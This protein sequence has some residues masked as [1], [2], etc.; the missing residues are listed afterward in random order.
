MTACRV[1]VSR[2]RTFF[3][4]DPSQLSLADGRA[5]VMSNLGTV[6]ALDPADG[7]VLWLS[8]Y[9]RD[10][11]VQPELM[12]QADASGPASTRPWGRNPVVVQGGRVFALPTDA[13]E[14]FV[15][16]AASG[17]QVQ[18]VE[19][20]DYENAD[21]L[22]GVRDGYAVLTS[23]RSIFGVDWQR[24]SHDHP[25]RSQWAEHVFGE[26]GNVGAPLNMAGRA[27]LTADGIYVVNGQNLAEID[28]RRHKIVAT[29]PARGTFQQNGGQEPGNLLVTSRNVVVAG[30]DRVDVYTDLGLVTARYT[31]EVAAS[32][33]DP[34]PRVRF[35]NALFAAGRTADAVA[36][37][38]EAIGLL[39][40]RGGMRPGAGRR[41]VFDTLLDFARRSAT[42]TGGVLPADAAA[43][44]DPLYDRAA[45][46]A[47]GPDQTV[48]YL[49]A[50]ARFDHDTNRGGPEVELCQRVL[51][52]PALRP[53]PVSDDQTAAAAATAAIAAAV[54]V[55]RA[56]YAPV[57]ARAAAAL[58]AA[59]QAGDTDAL[60]A[61]SDVYPNSGAASDARQAAV[62]RFEA[63]GQPMR[64]V[65]VLR[66]TY[67]LAASRPT[68]RPAVLERIATAFLA[69]GPGGA[70]PAADRMARAAVLAT[71]DPHLA[72]DFP[73]PDGTTLHG[74]TDTYV[75]AV[76][77]LR[78]ELARQSMAGL[79]DFRLP[80][81]QQAETQFEA[82]HGGA[83]R[84]PDSP[85]LNPFLPT[86][87][88]I[89]DVVAVVHPDRPF[90]RNDRVVTWS[91]AGLGVYAVGQ[92][93]PAFTVASVDEP[94]VGGA[95][96]GG[97]L[98]AWTGGRLTAVG[99]DDGRPAWAV[100]VAGLAPLPA[101]ANPVGTAVVDDVPAAV[102]DADNNNVPGQING[103]VINIRVNGLGQRVL[104]VR[105]GQ[106][107]IGP[108]GVQGGG[109][110][111]APPPAGLGGGE[112]I[113]AV[114]PAGDTLVVAT[115]RGRLVGVDA[116]TGSVRWQARPSDRAADAVLANGHYAVVRLDDGGGSQVVVYDVPTGRTIGRRRFGSAGQPNQL[117]NV[118]LG[119]EATLV[120][121]RANS[122]E[123]KDLYDPWRDPMTPLVARSMPDTTDY[124]GLTQPDQLLVQAGRVV[125]L[126]ASGGNWRAW[127]L[128]QTTQEASPPMVASTAAVATGTPNV[129]LRLDGPRLLVVQP[130]TGVSQFNLDNPGD[131]VRP[132][133][134]VN[135]NRSP[136]ICG[137]MV[138]RE[139]VIAIDSETDRG[140]APSPAVNVLCYSRALVPGTTRTNGNLDFYPHQTS[141]VGIGDW[142]GVDGG[143]YFLN[144]QQLV[145][146]RGGRD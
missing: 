110:A 10:G 16:D 59:K 130:T 115:T 78:A 32:P 118:A 87:S 67:A 102:A 24:Y 139:H 21:V 120:V 85:P 111:V 50:R 106:I 92:T 101:V 122:I 23:N 69:T 34:D 77:A 76:T 131:V 28:W 141:R 95:W 52:D 94:P 60:L 64:A 3:S 134:Q 5:F 2:P 123:V 63:A 26:D 11:L 82:L 83:K 104:V 89:R 105:N 140:P 127:D 144:G 61:V 19:L 108:A 98:L 9:K 22:L 4:Q 116:A 7:R 20:A 36:K 112:Q 51:S 88:V 79:P 129:W 30:P 57:E 75:A 128:A 81:W 124:A 44:V 132:D 62:E 48:A 125:A 117:V 68:D 80:T 136:R 14:L 97:R 66:Q 55:N 42:P 41:L 143:V 12:Q 65:D 126:Y 35:A 145:F 103:Q 72:R 133:D 113:V 27:F 8:A 96:A 56:V 71:G 49:L 46:A 18:Q 138:G 74:G 135:G 47:D 86:L 37:V 137:V 45:D 40:G 39:G 6:A 109:P 15:F 73:L 114:R 90:A 93:T 119:E 70:G 17:K 107:V 142:I 91:P 121:T 54:D 13:K 31:G 38:D 53:V 43:A 146:K 84:T 25:E 29:Y 1:A 33:D 99:A 58:A 100:A